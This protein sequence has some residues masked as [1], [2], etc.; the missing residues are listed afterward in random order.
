[1]AFT[2]D[3]RDNLKEN[4][5]KRERET[6]KGNEIPENIEMRKAVE[7]FTPDGNHYAGT[8]AI[9]Y[10]VNKLGP[11]IVTKV[12]IIGMDRIEESVCQAG[13]KEFLVRVFALYGKKPPKKRFED[14]SENST[15]NN[16]QS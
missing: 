4:I 3:H 1:M 7:K 9:S 10:Y 12:Q 15:G 13:L 16:V 2:N 5:I 14:W 8:I 6:F 11:E